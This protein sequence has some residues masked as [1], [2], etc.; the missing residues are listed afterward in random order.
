MGRETEQTSEDDED[1]DDDDEEEEEDLWELLEWFSA[2]V[3]GETLDLSVVEVLIGTSGGISF[4]GTVRK[5]GLFDSRPDSFLSWLSVLRFMSFE[6]DLSEWCISLE[7]LS[8]PSDEL[9]L[10]GSFFSIG[11]IICL[12]GGV[13]SLPILLHVCANNANGL[14]LASSVVGRGCKYSG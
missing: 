1:E 5:P 9:L 11:G 7:D 4:G 2:A 3:G 6:W 14:F 10:L 8:L 13:V 12:D